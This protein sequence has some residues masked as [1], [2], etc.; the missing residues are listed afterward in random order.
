MNDVVAGGALHPVVDGNIAEDREQHAS[1]HES[2]A[3]NAIRE[4][5]EG[6]EEWH[7]R[8]QCDRNYNV[9][10]APRHFENRLQVEESIEL[11]GV[12]DNALAGGGAKERDENQLQIGPVGERLSERLG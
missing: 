12:P 11:A 9:G 5:A 3:A 1:H 2:L 10:R 4:R 8:K 6:G 7:G